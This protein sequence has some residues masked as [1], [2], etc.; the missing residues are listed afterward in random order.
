MQV[1]G[2][3]ILNR[4]HFSVARL[5]SRRFYFDGQ[6]ALSRRLLIAGTPSTDQLQLSLLDVLY[7]QISTWAAAIQNQLKL[8]HF[9]RFGGAAVY[10]K[11]STD[12]R[13]IWTIQRSLYSP[14]VYMSLHF[15]IVRVSDTSVCAAMREAKARTYMKKTS[16][17]SARSP[18]S[19]VRMNQTAIFMI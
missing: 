10:Y 19:E 3:I 13:Q 9:P 14:V 12:S 15:I 17:A 1:L 18:R 5:D 11:L 16:S 2:F 4:V 7:V 8:Q 6:T